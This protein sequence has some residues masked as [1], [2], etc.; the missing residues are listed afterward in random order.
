[1]FFLLDRIN[2]EYFIAALILTLAF[3][4]MLPYAVWAGR[5]GW[6]RSMKSLRIENQLS[7][8]E[9]LAHIKAIA[10]EKNGMAKLTPTTT[11]CDRLR[12]RIGL[13]AALPPNISLRL[14]GSFFAITRVCWKNPPCR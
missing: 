12:T 6:L 7:H 5:R 1:M 8:D 2:I 13:S 9:I 4:A 3:A 14:R 10:Q 11:A